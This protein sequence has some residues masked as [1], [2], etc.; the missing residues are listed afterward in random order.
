MVRKEISNFAVFFYQKTKF[1]EIAVIFFPFNF[2]K[3][4]MEYAM[5]Y[6]YVLNNL[7]NA[8]AGRSHD[9][10]EAIIEQCLEKTLL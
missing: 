1:Y 3:F 2:E 9:I 4:Q 6:V 10:M 5:P 8:E 7:C